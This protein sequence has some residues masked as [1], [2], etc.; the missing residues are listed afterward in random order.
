MITL[1]SMLAFMLIPI[2]IPLITVSVGAL[3][4]LLRRRSRPSG[5]PTLHA[6]PAAV[7]Q[8]VKETP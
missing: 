6:N 4:D 5:A 3:G 8:L 7:P 1:L 2:W